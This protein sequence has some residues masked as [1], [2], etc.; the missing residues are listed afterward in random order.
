MMIPKF[1]YVIDKTVFSLSIFSKRH[2]ISSVAG[3][4][5]TAH[6]FSY[7]VV[8]IIGICVHLKDV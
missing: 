8:F 6:L 5:L 4:C 1:Y 2:P 7:V 3:S